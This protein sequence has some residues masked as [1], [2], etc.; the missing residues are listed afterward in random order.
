M[1]VGDEVVEVRDRFEIDG[2][3]WSGVENA[4]NAV[5]AGKFDGVVNRLQRNFELEDDAVGGLESVGGGVHVGGLKLVVRALDDDDAIL[6]GGIDED[7][8][9]S[10]GNS[11]DL[12]DVGGVDAQLFK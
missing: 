12:A 9:D 11:G 7:G 10:T 5:S 8:G 4:A 6:A 3:R 1:L 2:L